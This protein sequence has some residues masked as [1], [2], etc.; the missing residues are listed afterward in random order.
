MLRY[1]YAFEY[2]SLS[3]LRE[4]Q[5]TPVGDTK[6]PIMAS[7]TPAEQSTEE[8]TEATPVGILLPDGL[9]FYTTYVQRDAKIED[10]DRILANCKQDGKFIF[11]IAFHAPIGLLKKANAY[12]LGATT[13]IKRVQGNRVEVYQNGVDP[14]AGVDYTSLAEVH[15]LPY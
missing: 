5:M 12:K 14:A 11:Q 10:F 3:D 2:I 7:S 9:T 4:A 15:E 8:A 13:R 6:E 1:R